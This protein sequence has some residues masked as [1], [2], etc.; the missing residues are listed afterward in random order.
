[1][2]LTHE[3]AVSM[4]AGYVNSTLIAQQEG[5]PFIMFETNTASCGGFPGIS[6][7]YGAALWVLD[8]GLSMASH[9]FSNA[10]LHVGGQNVYY[11]VSHPSRA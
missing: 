8:W 10:L 11:N 5:I 4:N 7:S 2:F 9:N 6:Q 3:T 1:M